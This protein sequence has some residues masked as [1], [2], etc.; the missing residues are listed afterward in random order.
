MQ[1][2]QQ[3]ADLFRRAVLKHPLKDA[4]SVGVSCQIVHLP[5]ACIDHELELIARDSLEAALNNVVGV[6]N[7]LDISATR[8]GRR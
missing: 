6:S 2:V 4:T 3:P 7:Q 8:K 5:S 1:L